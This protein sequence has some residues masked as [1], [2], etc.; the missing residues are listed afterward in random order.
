MIADSFSCCSQQ[1]CR[2]TSLPTCLDGKDNLHTALSLN[3]ALPAGLT[4]ALVDVPVPHAWQPGK[5]SQGKSLDL[6]KALP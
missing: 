5:G 4:S 1:S 3:S 2:T 6:E